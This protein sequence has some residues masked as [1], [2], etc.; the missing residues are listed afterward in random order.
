[1]ETLAILNNWFVIHISARHNMLTIT[2]V[3]LSEVYEVGYV[4]FMNQIVD[5]PHNQFIVPID[6]HNFAFPGGLTKTI[7]QA[8]QCL[9]NEKQPADCVA[10]NPNLR[11]KKLVYYPPKLY[12]AF[13]KCA[14][15]GTE[16]NVDIRHTETLHK[17]FNIVKERYLRI[18]GA[19]FHDFSVEHGIPINF[20]PQRLLTR[21]ERTMRIL[22]KPYLIVNTPDYPHEEFVARMRE[23]FPR[24]KNN[25]S[26]KAISELE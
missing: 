11:Y 16:L 12:N 2:H 13:L 5:N 24:R 6:S 1:M 19:F 7:R 14:F 22:G 21:G 26:Q 17:I 8:H 10:D 20:N 3:H 15:H 25:V 9:H 4:E 18:E 23:K